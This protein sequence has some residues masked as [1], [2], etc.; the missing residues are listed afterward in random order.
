MIEN[1]AAISSR[2]AAAD[3]LEPMLEPGEHVV[4]IATIS[5]G[6]FWKSIALAIAAVIALFYSL[7]L[8]IYL[9]VV[10]LIALMLALL[11]RKY[12][13]LAATDQRV[14]IRYGIFY[15]EVVEMRYDRVES[16]ELVNSFMGQL[17][18][19]AN[20]IITGTG[21]LRYGVPF[22]ENGFEFTTELNRMLVKNERERRTVIFAGEARS[23]GDGSSRR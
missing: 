7:T 14:I 13:L 5:P 4:S 11:T 19:Y 6:I 16:V 18:G 2:S 17:V 9:A 20:V 8:S 23:S 21:R 3:L 12:L 1:I 15:I 10:A 22:V